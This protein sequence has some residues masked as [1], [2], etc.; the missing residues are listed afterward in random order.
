MVDAR[1]YVI[2]TYPAFVRML[3]MHIAYT[4]VGLHVA[5]LHN[6]A[7]RE[8]L[9]GSGNGKVPTLFLLI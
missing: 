5:V 9:V 4:S 3:R 6:W 2:A 1:G 8:P 7:M